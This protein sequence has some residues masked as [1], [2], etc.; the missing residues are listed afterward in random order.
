MTCES[1]N[2]R[3][4]TVALTRIKG[5]HKQVLHLCPT[6]AQHGS[7]QAQGTQED[8]VPKASTPEVSTPKKVVQVKNVEVIVGHLSSAEDRPDI[9]CSGCGMTY[10]EFRQG[11]RLGCAACYRAFGSQLERLLKRIHGATRHAGK[12]PVASGP[13]PTAAEEMEQLRRDLD[14]AVAEEAYERAAQLRDRI[15]RVREELRVDPVYPDSEED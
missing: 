2:E 13:G 12:T 1:C 4:A 11:G 7:S 15:A 6:C 8:E 14:N 5:D 3:E 9:T 10:D